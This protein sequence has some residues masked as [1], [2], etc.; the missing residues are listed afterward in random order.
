MPVIPLVRNVQL[1]DPLVP[2]AR[3]YHLRSS[4]QRGDHKSLYP[5]FYFREKVLGRIYLPSSGAYTMY[6][7]G[8]SPGTYLISPSG[9]SS[10]YNRVYSKF[11]N[12]VKGDSAQLGATIGEYKSS[13]RMIYGRA[14]AILRFTTT[15]KKQWK[16]KRRRKSFREQYRDFADYWLEYSFG[17]APLLGDIYSAYKRMCSKP[18]NEKYSS[19]G[20]RE[21]EYG[22]DTAGVEHSGYYTYVLRIF[23]E[24]EITNPNTALLADLGLLNPAQIAWELMPWSFVA[25]WMFDIG[26]F[27][28]SWSD[29]IGR[30]L[31][32]DGISTIQKGFTLQTWT[33]GV[34]SSSC[35]SVIYNRYG[36]GISLPLPNLDILNN[37]GSNLKRAAN[38]LALTTQLVA[39]K[40][41]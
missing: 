10:L 4:G 35:E 31:A 28:S 22:L 39:K 20:K 12:K 1:Y 9:Y 6:D 17:W 15:L 21:Q 41:R 19:G 25:D 29:F 5:Y 2:W 26:G 36:A 16:K 23:G 33:D 34:G 27:L 40:G 32:N 37:V 11:V 13:S 8:N 24:V 18:K 38:A 7:A 30:E 14:D 3:R